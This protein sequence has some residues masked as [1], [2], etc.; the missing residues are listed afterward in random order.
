MRRSKMSRRTNRTKV[1]SRSADSSTVRSLSIGHLP[2]PWL[3]RVV[4]GWGGRRPT[5]AVGAL[6]E[7]RG[8]AELG[9][10]ALAIAFADAGGPGQASTGRRLAGLDLR[11]IGRSGTG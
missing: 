4:V 3:G 7:R 6:G 2:S 1:P 10:Q 8:G 11:L 9:E 5:V